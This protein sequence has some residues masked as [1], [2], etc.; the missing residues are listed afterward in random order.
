MQ[1]ICRS[2]LYTLTMLQSRFSANCILRLPLTGRPAPAI[3]I[4]VP[5]FIIR[6]ANTSMIIPVS[7][8]SVHE[9]LHKD[10]RVQKQRAETTQKPAKVDQDIASVDT[11]RLARRAMT[12]ATDGLKRKDRKH[13]RQVADA[14]ENEEKRIQA[15]CALASVIQQ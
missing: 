11:F 3:S 1:E 2:M 5:R 13:I 15:L 8:M 9:E 14:S 10:S 12:V 7:R 4:L 6:C